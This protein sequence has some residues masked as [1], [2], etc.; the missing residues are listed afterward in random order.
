MVPWLKSWIW[1]P[2][3]LSN[4][5]FHTMFI[6]P[7]KMFQLYAPLFKHHFNIYEIP[8]SPHSAKEMVDQTLKLFKYGERNFVFLLFMETHF[9]YVHP[10][11]MVRGYR[12]PIEHQRRSVEILD[13]EFGR[14]IDAL[15]GT[16]TDVIV[17]SDH[18]D[19]DYK[20]EGDYGHGHGKF[21]KKLFE[22][23]LGRATI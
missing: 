12:Y 13:K 7:N 17:F 1:V 2:T 10:R 3:D 14:L 18:G 5:D 16:S 11:E 21:H 6:T 8:K 15:G 19:L 22:I 23:P 20:R 9:P 4:M